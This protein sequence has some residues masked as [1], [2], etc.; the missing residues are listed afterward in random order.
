M[1]QSHVPYGRCASVW[2]S[3]KTKAKG[4]RWARPERVDLTQAARARVVAHGSPRRLITLTDDSF[5]PRSPHGH[6]K[7]HLRLRPY[8]GMRGHDPREGV[9]VHPDRYCEPHIKSRTEK[10][11]KSGS[12]NPGCPK[13]SHRIVLPAISCILGVSGRQSEVKSLLLH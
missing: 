10:T 9:A 5:L 11:H 8:H 7:W 12:T 6:F 2:T 4:R 3:M 1:Q 13:R